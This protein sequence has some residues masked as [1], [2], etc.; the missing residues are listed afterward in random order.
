MSVGETLRRER[1]RRGL[2]L[3]E[4]ARETKIR[5]RLLE[6]IE[7]DEFDRLPGSVFAKNFVKQYA[8]VLGLDSDELAG[9]V[10]KQI[11]PHHLSLAETPAIEPIDTKP[12]PSWTSAGK[13]HRSS[14]W[15]ALALFGAVLLGSSLAYRWWQNETLPRSAPPIADR[16][17]PPVLGEPDTTPL[18]ATEQIVPVQEPAPEQPG[19]PTAAPP[20]TPTQPGS[21]APVYVTLS[22]TEDT[23]VRVTSD[24]S[25][26]FTGILG[27]E[28]NRTVEASNNVRLRVGNAGGL[29]VTLNGKPVGPIGP[30]GQVREV[31]LTPSGADIQVP[32]PVAAS[33]VQDIF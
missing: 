2:H 32:R 27:P 4:V 28:E 13:T 15:P 22:A 19:S 21:G 8:E 7:D 25:H 1:V 23:W 18:S 20:L 24:G 26:S 12:L 10:T 5:Q 16:E 11:A 29:S 33:P 31:E 30:R 14:P 9:E 3:E 6:H 17:R